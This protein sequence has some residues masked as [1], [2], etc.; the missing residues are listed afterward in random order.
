MV[1][2]ILEIQN[3]R[4]KGRRIKVTEKELIVGRDEQCKI[5]IAS[6]EVSRQHCTLVGTA[7]GVIVCDLDSSNGTFIN[8]RPIKG[9]ALL[10]A[11]AVLTIG[12]MTLQLHGDA[13]PPRTS[14]AVHVPKTGSQDIG[15]LEDDIASWLSPTESGEPSTSDTTIIDLPV[16]GSSME[17]P[18]V[19]SDPPPRRRSFA[20]VAEEAADII[21]RW[22]AQGGE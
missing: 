9:Q 12:P 3:G 7:Q 13:E 10:R 6:E 18:V 20:S 4:F 17:I 2:H 8:G 1:L 22:R 19:P 16:S 5:R 14:P 21:E 15:V 11:G